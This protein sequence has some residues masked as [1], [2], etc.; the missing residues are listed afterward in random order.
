VGPGGSEMTDRL[1]YRLEEA[2]DVI[3]VSVDYFNEHVRSE[4]RVVRR[5]RCVIVP[6][7]EL[8][9]WLEENAALAIEDRSR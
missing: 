8:E 3:G 7:F 4:L 1:A 2:A 9:R 6:R 5:G